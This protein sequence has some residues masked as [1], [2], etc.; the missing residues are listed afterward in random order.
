MFARAVAECNVEGA[1]AQLAELERWVAAAAREGTAA[2][3]VERHLFRQVLA[4]GSTLLGAFFR[5]VGSGDLGETLT[6]GNGQTVS[7][8]PHEQARRLV[9][10]FGE[11]ALPR[12][13]YG[14]RPGQKIELAPTD[15]RLQLPDGDGSYLLQEGDQMLGMDQA[16][17]A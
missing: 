10:V 7:R 15:Q 2:H 14:T 17:G 9:T 8:W 6:L 16:F 3:A 12:C 4:I 1:R 5:S 13:V 11:F